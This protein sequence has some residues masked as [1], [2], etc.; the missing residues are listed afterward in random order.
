ML[1]YDDRNSILSANLLRRIDPLPNQSRMILLRITYEITKCSKDAVLCRRRTPVECETPIHGDESLIKG[2]YIIYIQIK[3]L[4]T[5]GYYHFVVGICYKPRDGW[6]KKYILLSLS[7]ALY[8]MIIASD[9]GYC[10]PHRL[11]ETHIEDLWKGFQKYRCNDR[12][13]TGF[14][15]RLL[16]HMDGKQSWYRDVDYISNIHI[17]ICAVVKF[18]H[19]SYHGQMKNKINQK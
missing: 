7:N 15:V 6:I 19:I 5:R 8:P 13:G 16:I 2:V 4:L 9:I 3:D 10:M 11:F 1:F 18:R 17:Q 14:C 12:V